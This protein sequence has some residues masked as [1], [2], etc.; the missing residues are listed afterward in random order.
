M[1]VVVKVGAV[2]SLDLEKVDGQLDFSTEIV[3]FPYVQFHLE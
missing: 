3:W 1:L 2:D